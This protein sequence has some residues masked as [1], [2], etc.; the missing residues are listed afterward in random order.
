MPTEFSE[1]NA[2]LANWICGSFALAILIARLVGHRWQRCRF[3]L[4]GYIVIASLVVLVARI[5][6]NS[7]VLRDKSVR[8]SSEDSTS[9]RTGSI[10][11][12]EYWS[13]IYLEALVVLTCKQ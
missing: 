13:T 1:Q 10:I 11:T 3:D 4:T 5:V 6:C 8:A 2:T 9:L 12:R 7:V